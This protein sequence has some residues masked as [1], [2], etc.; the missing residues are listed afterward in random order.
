M[1]AAAM[2][3]T[4]VAVLCVLAL[5][6]CS[7]PEKP[8]TERPPAPQAAASL[9]DADTWDDASKREKPA[10]E[11]SDAIQR[12]INK[13]KS[14]EGTTLEAADEQRAAIDAQERGDA[15]PPSDQ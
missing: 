3:R 1:D 12:P 11:L 5:G 2:S 10:T 8:E 14:V 15:P 7:K 9:P 13:A 6:A 4:L